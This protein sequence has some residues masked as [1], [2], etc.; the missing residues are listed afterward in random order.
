MC[1]VNYVAYDDVIRIDLQKVFGEKQC[2]QNSKCKDK[3]Y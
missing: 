2:R 3:H 1:I